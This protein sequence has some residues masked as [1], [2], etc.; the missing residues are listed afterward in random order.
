MGCDI[1][2]IVEYKHLKFKQIPWDSFGFY[3]INPGRNY[4]W[5]AN[6]AG[7]RGLPRK[8]K[9]YA[10]ELNFPQDA[11]YASRFQTAL[12]FYTDQNEKNP[13]YHTFGWI[14]YKQWK[15]SVKGVKNIHLEAITAV[16]E[17]FIKNKCDTRVVF[18]FDN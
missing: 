10:S 3:S 18:W 9:I 17:T 8:G 4:E 16:L 7:V 2:C 15:K 6:L 11:S 13:N 5:F 14:D 1:H 12:D